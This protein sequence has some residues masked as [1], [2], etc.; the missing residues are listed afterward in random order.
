MFILN[1]ELKKNQYMYAFSNF[2]LAGV[3]VH[4]VLKMHRI[5]I[6]CII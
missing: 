6:N 1:V 2:C 3:E 5:L 4:T